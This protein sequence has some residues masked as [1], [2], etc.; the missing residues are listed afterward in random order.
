MSIR[1]D[2]TKLFE[3]YEFRH[4]RCTGSKCD[5]ETDGIANLTISCP[6]KGCRGEV[7]QRRKITVKS[8]VDDSVEYFNG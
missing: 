1:R 5:F 4:Y 7:L 6:T 8:M 2:L 3:Q